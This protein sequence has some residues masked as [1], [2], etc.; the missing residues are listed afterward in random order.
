[1]GPQKINFLMAQ[2]RVPVLF[3]ISGYLTDKYF[4]IVWGWHLPGD[5]FKWT[6]QME[7]QKSIFEWLKFEFYFFLISVD[8]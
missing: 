5:P 8:I 4:D 7:P 1:M 3:D 6:P 2:A